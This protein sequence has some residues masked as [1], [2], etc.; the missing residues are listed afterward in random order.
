MAL[1]QEFVKLGGTFLT[2]PE[3]IYSSLTSVKAF[4]FDWD[5]VFND[6]RKTN[7]AD[8]TFSEVDSMGI[9]LLRFDYWLR[10]NRIPLIFII[11]G[12]KNKAVTYFSKR[13]HLD[14]IFLNIKNKRK[15]LE[16]ICKK[17]TIAAKEIAFIFDDVLDIEVA[18]LSG[19]S[20]FV[21]RK[22]NPLLMDYVVQNKICNYISA[23]SGEN[24]AV[25]EICELIIGLSG[26]YN[27]ALELRIQFKGEYEEYLKER[28]TI[29]TTVAQLK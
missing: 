1:E 12:M 13:E 8:S 5:G 3:V 22:S 19:L 2:P 23:F 29:N 11:T 4:V 7:D 24:H 14:G 16:S 18:K 25:R 9:N 26:D 21:G 10:Y 6:G 20:F 28:S 15:A 17:Y 27:R